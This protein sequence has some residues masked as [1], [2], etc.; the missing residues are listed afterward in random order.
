MKRESLHPTP[1]V[2]LLTSS[3]LLPHLLLLEA[4]IRGVQLTARLRAGG[5]NGDDLAFWRAVRC[6]CRA[7]RV[8]LALEGSAVERHGVGFLLVA[9]CVLFADG[10]KVARLRQG[11]ELAFFRVR[12]CI[13]WE[14]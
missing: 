2:L 9:R 13:G 3:V 6:P 1:S 10:L 12:V 7:T 14:G 5:R 4:S 11:V 8:G